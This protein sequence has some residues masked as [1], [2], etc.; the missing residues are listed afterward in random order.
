MSLAGQPVAA[1]EEREPHLI[2]EAATRL[3]A[4]YG[5]CN[6]F[7]GSY[8]LE[9]ESLAFGP[10][11][12]TRMACADGMELEQSFHSALSRTARWR[13]SGDRFEILDAGGKALA[14]FERRR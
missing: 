4:G 9:G 3:A 1:R 13:I 8:T 12:S 10:L 7:T 14:G 5:G 2:L 6:R 11:A